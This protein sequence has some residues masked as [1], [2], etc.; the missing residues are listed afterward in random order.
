MHTMS[1]KTIKYLALSLAFSSTAHA[2]KS[3][4]DKPMDVNADRFEGQFKDGVST[5]I[6]NVSITQGTLLAKADKAVVSQNDKNEIVRAVLTGSP[7]TLVQDLDDGGK[8]DIRAQE[9]NYDKVKNSATL[10]GNA[11]VKQPRGEVT[12]GYLIYD[13]TSKQIKGTGDE[14]TGRVS[15]RIYPQEKADSKSTKSSPEQ[16]KPTAT[17]P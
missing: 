13:L 7:A 1:L 5:L 2:L 11:Y 8:L 9:I 3:D 16:S 17:T 4:S 10:S 14:S 15:M 12:G 6:G